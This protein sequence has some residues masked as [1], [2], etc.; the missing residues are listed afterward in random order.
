MSSSNRSLIRVPVPQRLLIS[1]CYS[2]IRVIFPELQVQRNHS[3]L[4]IIVVR[5]DRSPRMGEAVDGLA[6]FK[7]WKPDQAT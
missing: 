2:K 5:I 3:A 7:P 1:G 4:P 6:M